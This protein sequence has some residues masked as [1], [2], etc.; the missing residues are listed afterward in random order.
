M[1]RLPL[2]K[3]EIDR[4]AKQNG[5]FLEV[6]E[7]YA[8]AKAALTY[9]NAA[10]PNAAVEARKTEYTTLAEELA[11]EVEQMLNAAALPEIKESKGLDLK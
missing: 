11:T 6:C 3:T 4:L 2:R 8:D 5:T 7:D 1:D 9:W 10:P